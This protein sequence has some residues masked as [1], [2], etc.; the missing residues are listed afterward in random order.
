MQQI[1]KS[2]QQGMGKWSWLA[3]IVALVFVATVTLRMAPHYVDF[4]VI[5]GIFD[6]LP[7]ASLHSDMSRGDIREHFTKKFRVE[8]FQF[9]VRDILTV[10]RDRDQTIVNMTYEIRELI[11]YNADVVLSFA[12]ERI[13]K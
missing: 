8:N 6:R 11:A 1:N 13:Y 4:K 5:V 10:T 7:K 3:T 2:R 12:K 9:K